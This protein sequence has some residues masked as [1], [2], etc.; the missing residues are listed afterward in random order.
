[1]LYQHPAVFEAGVIGSPDAI[2]GQ[3]VVAFVSLRNGAAPGEQELR[4][5]TR[6]SLADYKV[7][8]RIF[9][10]PALP[11]GTTGKVHRSALKAMLLREVGHPEAI[12]A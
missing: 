9:F 1:M 7:P 10:I 6:R 5:H 12:V 4:E 2:Y 3:T 8:E 11:K